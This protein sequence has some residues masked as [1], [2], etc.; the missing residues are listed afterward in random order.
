VL[1][2]QRKKK[3]ETVFGERQ[4][5][6]ER[7]FYEA[8]FQDIGI[9][10]FV[11]KKIRQILEEVLNADLS[12][13]SSKDD[14]SKNLNFFWEED[15]LADVEIFEQIEEEF[16]IKFYQEDFKTL[17]TLKVNDIVNIV[18]KKVQNKDEFSN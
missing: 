5:L 16:S 3:I 9:P 10:F 17:E 11:V 7:D 15:S 6:S 18:R 13:L 12:R 14:F 1:I 4:E 2:K 8:Y